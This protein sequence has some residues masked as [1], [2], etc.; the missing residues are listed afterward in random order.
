MK[1]PF[2]YKKCVAF[3]M[4]HNYF[5]N[6]FCQ[7]NDEY[8]C[9]MLYGLFLNY[10]SIKRT[11]LLKLTRILEIG[12]STEIGGTALLSFRYQVSNR[13]T[14]VP[15]LASSSL[16]SCNSDDKIYVGIGRYPYFCP[17]NTWNIYFFIQRFL[18]WLFLLLLLLLG[19]S[20]FFC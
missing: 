9:C 6:V 1:P 3:N 18:L 5:E 10:N 20:F 15:T 8:T 17:R 13:E 7:I 19:S 14:S 16:K 12:C 2:S 11:L 4:A